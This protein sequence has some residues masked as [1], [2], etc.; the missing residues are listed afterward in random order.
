L[1]L[2]ATATR[3]KIDPGVYVQYVERTAH[4]GIDIFTKACRRLEAGKWFPKLHELL[5]ECRIVAEYQSERER[6][7]RPRLTERPADPIKVD[8]FKAAVQARLERARMK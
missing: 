8:E 4:V 3:E 7:A 2:I 1:T 6:Q 5:E